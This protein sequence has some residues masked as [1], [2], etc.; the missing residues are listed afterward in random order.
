LNFLIIGLG[1]AGQRHARAIRSEFPNSNIYIFRGEH[2]TGLISPDLQKIDNNLDPVR[3]Y[4]LQEL[5]NFKTPKQNYDLTVVATPIANHFSHTKSIW[6]FSNRILIEKPITL[7]RKDA[8]D[9][10]QRAILDKK[11][12]HV[13][14]QHTF[15]PLLNK[16]KTQFETF[17]PWTYFECE[18]SEYLIDMNPFREMQFHHLADPKEGNVFLALSHEVDFLFQ[19]IPNSWRKLE[20]R[21]LTS[22]TI[23]NALDTCEIRANFRYLEANLEIFINLNFDNREK[24]RGGVLRNSHLELKWNLVD[25]NLQTNNSLTSFLF[26]TDYLFKKQ[27]QFIL[28]KKKFDKEILNALVRA[29]DIVRLNS[30]LIIN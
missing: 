20:G 4:R 3:Y 23:R 18:F 2:Y 25:N 5:D 8:E 6:S 15:S 21:L 17:K 10:L 12:L 24:K 30:K 11:V 28:A 22:S 29:V 16:V 26:D 27:L 13:G 9:L 7:Y 19:L 1:S 14:Y